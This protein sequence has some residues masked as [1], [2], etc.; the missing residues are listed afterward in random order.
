MCIML[1]EETESSEI[2]AWQYKY[3]N[4]ELVRNQYMNPESN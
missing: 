1:I 4:F 3:Q 2:R